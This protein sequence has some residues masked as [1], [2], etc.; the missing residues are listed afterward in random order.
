[1][2]WVP[3]WTFSR[4][5]SWTHLH[6]TT[7]IFSYKP[8]HSN[9]MKIYDHQH[10]WFLENHL[11]IFPFKNLFV[12]VFILSLFWL[13]QGGPHKDLRNLLKT[14]E[15][16]HQIWRKQFKL[17]VWIEGGGVNNQIG[18]KFIATFGDLHFIFPDIPSWKHQH[19]TTPSNP[20]KTYQNNNTSPVPATIM[21][22]NILDLENH[23]LIFPFKR[24]FVKVLIL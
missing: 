17:N 11:R 6:K 19:R 15:I 20:F 2:L 13:H 24:L 18:C 21:I 22:I 23:L 3:A 14:A 10:L 8:H 5:A 16:W 4:K 1:M 12:K 9:F 7:P